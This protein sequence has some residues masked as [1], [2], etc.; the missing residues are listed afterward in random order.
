MKTYA[1]KIFSVLL[2]CF[3]FQKC[4]IDNEKQAPVLPPESSM[5]ADFSALSKAP[6]KSFSLDTI[7]FMNYAAAYWTVAIW[8]TILTVNLAVPVLAF[9]ESFNHQATYNDSLDAWQWKYSVKTT[10]F[11]LAKLKIDTIIYT[12]N[13]Q[14]KVL[15]D[16]IDWKM[17]LTKTSG[18]SP[19]NNFLWY[20]GKSSIKTKGGWWIMNERPANPQ[21]FLSIIW[22]RQN[23]S[24]G[25]IKYTNIR[26]NSTGGYL[27]YGTQLPDVNNMN[28]YYNVMDTVN[29]KT[30]EIRVNLK[31]KAGRIKKIN[32]TKWSCWDSQFHDITC[33]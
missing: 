17:Y 6:Q 12:A 19:F 7:S 26:P 13:L 2:V 30:I 28:A 1:L 16:S 14:G 29:N 32:E 27:E 23:D 8:N 22:S 25:M 33:E 21:K 15:D 3:L 9:R 24:I 11:V 31:T 18:N 20:Y 10:E 5:V 4:Q